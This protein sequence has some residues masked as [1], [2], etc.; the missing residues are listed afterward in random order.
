M[1]TVR[2]GGGDGAAAATPLLLAL[3]HWLIDIDPPF[4]ALPSTQLPPPPG[5][6]VNSS[7]TRPWGALEPLSWSYYLL[8]SHTVHTIGFSK[9]HSVYFLYRLCM[10]RL[11]RCLSWALKRNKDIGW[12]LWDVTVRRATFKPMLLRCILWE[13][14][15]IFLFLTSPYLLYFSGCS[16]VTERPFQLLKYREFH[17]IEFHFKDERLDLQVG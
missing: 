8:Y 1:G 2:F 5:K 14:T 13:G 6:Q 3:T 12:E 9:N 7:N 15:H 10:I 11:L 17:W 4:P 16:A